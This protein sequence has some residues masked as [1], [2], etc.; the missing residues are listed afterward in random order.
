[1][2]GTSEDTNFASAVMMRLVATGLEK[3]SLGGLLKPARGA[4]VPRPSK[5]SFLETIGEEHGLKTILRLADAIPDMPPEPVVL[6]LTKARDIDDLFER[7]HRIETFSHAYHTVDVDQ[8]GNGTWRLTHVS[9]RQGEKPTPE[10]S[11][12]VVAVLTR[13]G[14][15]V[16]NSPLSLQSASGATLRNDSGWHEPKPCE[17]NAS[18]V[19]VAMNDNAIVPQQKAEQHQDLVSASKSMLAGDLVRRWTLKDL[20]GALGCSTRSLQRRYSQSAT[21]FSTLVSEA[22]LEAAAAYL[23]SEEKRSLAEIG[24]LAGYTDQAHFSRSFMQQVGTTP[25]AYR[26][27]FSPQA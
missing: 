11:L 10:E 23:C 8:S 15:T 18:F 1:M 14:E 3:Q 20:A 4:H 21:T 5:R 16:C 7:W 27:S 26:T 17:I 12:L 25:N 9:R 22:R 13:L 24:F 2:N 6:A 19:L